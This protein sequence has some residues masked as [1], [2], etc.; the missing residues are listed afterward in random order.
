[1][2]LRRQWVH[3]C[4]LCAIACGGGAK[5]ET[6]LSPNA[7]ADRPVLVAGTSPDEAQKKMQSLILPY[8][9]QARATLPEA[10]RRYLAGLPAGE[11]FFVTAVLTDAAGHFEQVFIKVDSTDAERTT[12][13]IASQIGIVAGYRYGDQVTVLD[14]DIIDWTISKPDGSEDGNYVGKFLDTLPR[15]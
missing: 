11:H 9:R 5:H 14:P 12:G 8:V 1:M 7:P 2:L 6:A 15:N 4:V 13:R 3:S 10:K